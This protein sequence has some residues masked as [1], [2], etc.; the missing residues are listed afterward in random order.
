[1]KGQ[2]HTEYYIAGQDWHGFGGYFF[3]QLKQNLTISNA[4]NALILIKTIPMPSL[5]F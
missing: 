5:K 2:I 4:I 3:S 1:M